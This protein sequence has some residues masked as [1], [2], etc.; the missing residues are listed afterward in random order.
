MTR[1]GNSLGEHS[2]PADQMGTDGIQRR[3]GRGGPPPSP[4]RSDPDTFSNFVAS[5][6]RGPRRRRLR[7]F[8]IFEPPPAEIL[9]TIRLAQGREGAGQ[10]WA[11]GARSRAA[12]LG[13]SFSSHRAMGLSRKTVVF[14]QRL[15]LC[16]SPLQKHTAGQTE[17]IGDQLC[18]RDCQAR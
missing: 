17:A 16:G 3:V 15:V 11:Q 10:N 5:N 9:I 18:A 12:L 4:T 6:A 14:G 2:R 7:P 1:S 8:R 13:S